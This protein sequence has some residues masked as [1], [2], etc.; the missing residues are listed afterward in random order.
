MTMAAIEFATFDELMEKYFSLELKAWDYII[1]ETKIMNSFF[2]EMLKHGFK[3]LRAYDGGASYDLADK[4][5]FTALGILLAV[6]DCSTI[7]ICSN[8]DEKFTLY[9]LLGEGETYPIYDH[10][11]MSPE[12]EK[13]IFE[14]FAESVREH[15][16]EKYQEFWSDM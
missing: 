1:L 11:D 12:L 5:Q 8:K 16:E 15:S 14:W 4:S 6:D 9:I 13:Q 2:T 7:T 10:S 3:F